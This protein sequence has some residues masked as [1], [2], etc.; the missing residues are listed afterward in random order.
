MTDTPT[1][2]DLL[3][4]AGFVVPIEPHGVVL[5]DHAVAV[6][7]GVIVDVLPITAARAKYAAKETVSR[8]DAVLMP[9]FVNAHTHNPMTLL[10]GIADD[11]PL[12]TWLQQHI[13]PA[14]ARVMS[15]EYV[16]DGATLAV[17][18]MLRGGTTCC[19]EN[20]FFPD[21]QAQT[22]HKLGFRAMVGLPVIDFP[23]AWAKS[24]DE[25][26]E[27]AGEVH[28][29]WRDDA[30]IGTAFAPHAPYTVS[31]ASFERLRMLSDQLDIPVHCHVH[32]TVQEVE[33]SLKLHGQRPLARLDRLG[34]VNDRLIAVHMT[35]LTDAEIRLCAERGTSVV[36]CPESNMKLASGFCPVE[37]LVRS[38]VNV[39]IGTDGAASNN[40]L[41]MFGETRTAALLAK[42]VANDAAAF[43]AADALRA[44]TLG[45]AHALGWGD[46]IGSIEVG[47]QAD[48]ALVDLSAIETQP[49][50]HVLSQLVYACGRQQVSDVWIA[51]RRKLADRVLVEMDIDAIRANARQWR[52]HIGVQ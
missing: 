18:E 2:C 22:Y 41:D 52:D 26:F 29:Q 34:V 17:A 32:E 5:D 36:H 7:A 44:A 4:E 25:Y 46:R 49:L 28:D 23:T 12:M 31:D 14:E 1:P 21:V 19:N 13:W 39:A 15:P 40:D 24:D 48:L 50:F 11:L 27:R 8:P 35:Q 30:F 38:G 6:R 37:K 20:Y 3:I 33:D 43:G 51:G 10:R 47:K 45:S 16:R 42:A 9:G